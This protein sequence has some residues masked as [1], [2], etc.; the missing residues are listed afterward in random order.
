MLLLIA[1][2]VAN[3]PLVEPHGKISV[4]GSDIPAFV[5]H[6]AERGNLASILAFAGHNFKSGWG[7]RPEPGS[8]YGITHAV[9]QNP[10]IRKIL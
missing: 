1:V 6:L 4:H 8:A 10:N 5:Q 3:A 2:G 7:E 9:P